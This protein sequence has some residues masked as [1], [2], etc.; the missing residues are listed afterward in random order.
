M[1]MMGEELAAAAPGPDRSAVSCLRP[2]PG[3]TGPRSVRSS[4]AKFGERTNQVDRG[5][6]ERSVVGSDRDRSL[7]AVYAKP[8]R[9][10]RYSRKWPGPRFSRILRITR[11]VCGTS[12][13][14]GK[15]GNHACW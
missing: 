11:S 13:R 3:R 4:N 10:S 7:A 5:P 15:G 1:A 12:L 6:E 2:P 8:P 14:A 9:Y